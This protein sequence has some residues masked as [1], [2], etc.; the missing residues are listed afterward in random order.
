MFLVFEAV[1]FSVIYTTVL[2]YSSG[3]MVFALCA[4]AVIGMVYDFIYWKKNS[5]AI[6][7]IRGAKYLRTKYALIPLAISV[8]MFTC[9][10]FVIPNA[11]KGLGEMIASFKTPTLGLAM[12]AY[13]DGILVSLAVAWVIICRY[14]LYPAI[15][16]LGEVFCVQKS[17]YGKSPFMFPA[18]LLVVIL[19]IPFM[20]VFGVFKGIVNSFSTYITSFK[21][22]IK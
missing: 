12:R 22:N 16:Q 6:R 9:S 19:L 8:V 2:G 4:G 5:N 20:A 10:A 13:I 14:A 18:T 11:P 7:D 21:N 3:K 15:D 1:L 17:F